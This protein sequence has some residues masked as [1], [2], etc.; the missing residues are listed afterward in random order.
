MLVPIEAIKPSSCGSRHC[1]IN[2]LAQESFDLLIGLAAEAEVMP[3]PEL[4]CRAVQVTSDS[5][6]IEP[7]ESVAA[8][9]DAKAIAVT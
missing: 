2:V 8:H 6:C 4:K 9:H 7:G 1:T 5:K 3:A